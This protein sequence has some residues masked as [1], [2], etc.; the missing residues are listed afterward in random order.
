MGD[1]KI[2]ILNLQGCAITEVNNEHEIS[3]PFP[4]GLHDT[5]READLLARFTFALIT[6][7]LLK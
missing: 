5:N 2:T 1:V 6:Y 7:G 4:G 3:I